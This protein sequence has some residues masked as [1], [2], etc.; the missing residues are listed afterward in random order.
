M[1]WYH[2]FSGFWGG[3]FL[4][5]FVPHFVNGVSGNGFPTPFAKP[6]GRG[7]SSP[8]VNVIW[9]LFNLLAG[10]LLY[11]FARISRQDNLS[12]L[13]FFA[14]I[15]IISILMSIRFAGKEKS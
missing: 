7:L 10:Y 11:R 2:Y 15:A 8:L 12:L 5:N 1:E 6:P 14:G 3:V 4:A 13:L 9:S